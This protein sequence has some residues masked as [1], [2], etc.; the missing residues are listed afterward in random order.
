MATLQ[1]YQDTIR[2]T[3]VSEI[4][5]ALDATTTQ[6]YSGFSKAGT[7]INTL[8]EWMVDEVTAAADNA[9]VEGTTFSSITATQPTRSVNFTQIFT[10]DVEVSDTQESVD[11]YGQSSPMAYQLAKEMKAM[12]ADIELAIV[13]G[14]GASGNATVSRRMAGVM[15]WITT[16]A[17]AF[18]SGTTLTEILLNDLIEL[19]WNNG[20]EVDEIYCG[21]K[22][23]RRISGFTANQ[24]RYM[25]AEDKRLVNAVDIYESDFGIHKIFK[26]RYVQV[27]ADATANIL[28]LDS[29]RWKIA[30]LKGRTPFTRD[31]AKVGDSTRKQMVAELTIECHQEKANAKA[32]GFLLG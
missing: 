1:T 7:A 31:I 19:T 5:Y 22:L 13:R 20:G 21:A 3:D 23:K 4:M 9:K 16:N 28:L 26:H 30:H 15:A 17:T 25:G 12:K 32:S 14:T 8:H 6:M 24:T 27:A 18:N 11:H 2:K 29:K 10:K